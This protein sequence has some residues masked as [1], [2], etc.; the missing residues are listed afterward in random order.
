MK[1]YLSALLGVILAV[2]V[3]TSC[4]ESKGLP[5]PPLPVLN[6]DLANGK[7]V[8]KSVV[9]GEDFTFVREYST[10]YNA[11]SWRITDSKALTMRAWVEGAKVTVLVEHVH[12]DISLKSKYEALDGWPQDT[13]DDSVHGGTQPGFFVNDK[14]PYENVFAI[15]GF[16]QTL[17]SGW[18]FFFSGFGQGN[19]QQTRLTEE[20]LVRSGKVYANKVQIVYDLLIKSDNEPYF[21]TRSLID[22]FLVPTATQPAE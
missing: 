20:N 14:Y 2:S 15:E 18:M 3:L 19:V 4:S 8:I 21:H 22:E 7:L 6:N 16:S 12:A 11:K 17:I 13:M 1:K 10:S 5:T 9:P